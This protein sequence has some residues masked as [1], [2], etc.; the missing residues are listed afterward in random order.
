VRHDHECRVGQFSPQQ[1]HDQ[2]FRFEI[3]RADG[4]V[5]KCPIRFGQYQ[6]YQRQSL[7][8]ADRE[9]DGA[10]TIA[11]GRRRTE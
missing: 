6:P 7:L 8:L 1:R 11:R 10:C 3:E 5:E 2:L 9:S 4:F